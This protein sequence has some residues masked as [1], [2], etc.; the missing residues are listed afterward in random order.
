MKA[1]FCLHKTQCL[2]TEAHIEMNIQMH[3]NDKIIL[4]YQENN[5]LS[6]FSKGHLSQETVENT[7]NVEKAIFNVIYEK[8]F[9]LP[10]I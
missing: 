7:F 6:H 2:A 10:Q 4:I 9:F 5:Q 3:K 8:C 1:I